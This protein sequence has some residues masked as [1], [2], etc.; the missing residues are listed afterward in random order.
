MA[1]WDFLLLSTCP[2]LCAAKS[3]CRGMRRE[4]AF[5][6]ATPCRILRQCQFAAAPPRQHLSKQIHEK[7]TTLIP[8]TAAPADG[9]AT[10]SLNAAAAQAR[11]VEARRVAHMPRC[12]QQFRRRRRDGVFTRLSSGRRPDVAAS[13]GSP[14]NSS[15][16]TTLLPFFCSTRSRAGPGRSSLGGRG[17]LE[18]PQRCA[19]GGRWDS[20]RGAWRGPRWWEMEI[21]GRPWYVLECDTWVGGVLG[22]AFIV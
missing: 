11:G 4:V 18:A 22:G 7:F 17:P 6:K 21:Q 19:A 10:G 16:P 15:R 5:V 12:A 9:S 20:S 1:L 8:A 14:A 2:A 3:S 13:P